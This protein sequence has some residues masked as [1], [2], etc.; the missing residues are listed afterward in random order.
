MLMYAH[1]AVLG[2]A[3]ALNETYSLRVAALKQELWSRQYDTGTF[4]PGPVPGKGVV[5]G[6]GLN[7]PSS[8]ARADRRTERE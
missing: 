5:V 2:A 7:I 8:P 4:P 1:L 3:I 6:L